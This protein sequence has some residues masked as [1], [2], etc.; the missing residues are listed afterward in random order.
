MFLNYGTSLD[1]FCVVLFIRHEPHIYYLAFNP[2]QLTPNSTP[3]LRRVAL[4]CQLV[5]CLP[6]V[7]EISL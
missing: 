6:T 4:G 5:L 2:L 3:D 7:L 1:R